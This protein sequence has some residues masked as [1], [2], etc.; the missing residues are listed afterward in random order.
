MNLYP[1]ESLSNKFLTS[2]QRKTDGP[3]S[4]KNTKNVMNTRNRSNNSSQEGIS[5]D[6]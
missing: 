2:I 6:N 5:V 3:S 1:Y 4:T